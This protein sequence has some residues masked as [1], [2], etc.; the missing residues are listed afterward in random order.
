MLRAARAAFG[1]FRPFNKT[2]YF[3]PAERHSIV[4][5][6]HRTADKLAAQ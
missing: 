2:L 3:D 6:T 4:E 1:S 5:A